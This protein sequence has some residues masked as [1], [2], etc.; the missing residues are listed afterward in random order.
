MYILLRSRLFF[1]EAHYIINILCILVYAKNIRLYVK[2]IRLYVKNKFSLLDCIYIYYLSN[3]LPLSFSLLG[4]SV[5]LRFFHFLSQSDCQHHKCCTGDH[6]HSQIQHHASI[7]D[8]FFILNIQIMLLDRINIV[9]VFSA[10]FSHRCRQDS[11][12]SLLIGSTYMTI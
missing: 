3:N 8:I 5:Q 1:F 11:L 4:S 9:C 12:S 7:S 2:N 6:S 10:I